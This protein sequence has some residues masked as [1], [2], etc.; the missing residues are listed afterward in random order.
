MV[1][2]ARGI[3]KP[4]RSKSGTSS[5]TRK[6]SRSTGDVES[7]PNSPPVTRSRATGASQAIASPR[8]SDPTPSPFSMHSADHPAMPGTEAHD[9]DDCLKEY[10]GN[11][12][13]LFCAP[14]IFPTICYRR[15]I[16]D[17]GAK[18]GRCV[19]GDDDV[20]CLCDFCSDKPSDQ[21]IRQV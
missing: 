6:P 16:S 15:C 8:F 11:V 9:D 17:K 19:W 1:A 12:G 7:P 18:G 2:I 21:F 14:R 5:A 13:F 10:G 3:R 4:T 20:K